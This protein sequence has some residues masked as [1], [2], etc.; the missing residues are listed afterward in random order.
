MKFLLPAPSSPS[1][2]PPTQSRGCFE[3]GLVAAVQTAQLHVTPRKRDYLNFHHRQRDAPRHGCLHPHPHGNRDMKDKFD[4]LWSATLRKIAPTRR[5]SGSLFGCTFDDTGSGYV[6]IAAAM[7]KSNKFD[8][9]NR[10][11]SGVKLGH[12]IGGALQKEAEKVKKDA[13]RH[14]EKVRKQSNGSASTEIG[15]G[16]GSDATRHVIDLKAPGKDLGDEGV[17]AV[18][19]GLEAALRSGSSI[20]SLAL[21]DLNLAGNGITTQSLARLVPIIQLAKCD[22]KTVN[23]SGNKIRVD[24]DEEAMQWEAFLR[25]FACCMKLRRLDLSGNNNLGARALEILARVHISEYPISPVELGGESSV[26]SLMSDDQTIIPESDTWESV[27][28]RDELD[29]AMTRG[30]L[31]KRRCGLRSIPYITLH[32]IQLD[33]AGALWLSYVLQD[34]FYPN[35]LIDELNATNADSVIKAYQQDTNSGGIDRADNKSAGKDGLHLLERTEAVR[36]RLLFED[37]NISI[38][39]T[40]SDSSF[41]PIE[42]PEP[43]R[44]SGERRTSRAN[45]GDRR[46]SL[47]SIRTEDGGEHETSEVDSSRRKIQRHLIASDGATSVELWNA[48]L[49]AIRASRMLL[50]IAPTTNKYTP[51]GVVPVS[52]ADS[53]NDVTASTSADSRGDSFLSRTPTNMSKID[54]SADNQFPFASHLTVLKPN[55]KGSPEVAITETTN[56]R[57]S[58][59]NPQKSLTRKEAFSEGTDAI[60]LST[61]LNALQLPGSTK[62]RYTEYQRKRTANVEQSGRS[63]RDMNA[64]CRLPAHLIE[65]IVAET[66]SEREIGVMGEWQKRETVAWGL[67]R[68]TLAQEREW[69]RKDDSAQV[70][71]L[72]NSV[73]CLAYEDGA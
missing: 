13:E 31:M 62:Q 67:K 71:L 16:T 39:S 23:I 22:L 38:T 6:D 5:R 40:R 34:H 18:A 8:Y 24:T 2:S 35:Q 57:V 50:F 72:L 33:D 7:G 49:K 53:I 63:F 73:R 11:N 55:R 4:K 1:P 51:A 19:E 47:W 36:R 15:F 60:S 46:A 65:R 44:N 54:V 43:R 32:D 48:A 10:A 70:W 28:P 61:R 21:E 68:E 29:T 27:G 17:F 20:G 42:M 69:L 41:S 52:R 14:L 58:S 64:A 59:P 9:S 45:A 66:M 12:I 3:S 25:A 30:R 26:Y 37:K 56:T